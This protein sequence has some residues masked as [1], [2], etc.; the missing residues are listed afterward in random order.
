MKSSF[1]GKVLDRIN[2]IDPENLQTYLV[3]LAQDK[4]FLEGIFNSIQ[5]GIIVTDEAGKIKYVNL[6]ATRLLGL[7]EETSLGMSIDRVI[8]NLD[9]KSLLLEETSIVREVELPYPDKKF[10]SFYLVPL[11]PP[12]SSKE[13]H[14]GRALI[15][16][17]V[18][19][20]RKTTEEAIETEKLNALMLLSASVAH[21]L[22]NP[23]NSIGIHLQLMERDLKHLPKDKAEKFRDTIRI[24][25]GEIT[26]LD[27]IIS[28]FLQAMRPTP[29]DFKLEQI[30]E[31]VSEALRF[32]QPELNDREIIVETDLNKNLPKV[33]LDQN[34]IKQV[35]YNLIRNAQQ[36]MSQEGILRVE[37]SVTGDHVCVSFID[38]GQGIDAQKLARIFQP[39]YTT[40]EKGSG[41]GLMIVQRI[42][43]AHG[44]EISVQSHTGKGTTFQVLLPLPEQR[45]RMLGFNE[46]PTLKNP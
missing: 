3:R 29:P 33:L 38:S 13:E 28:Q 7:D 19:E 5:E 10:I 32:L 36:A 34:Q 37:T 26:R 31:V 40:K 15:L 12:E 25:R 44:G 39:F 6:A 20:S 8:K 24:C 11:L 18:T 9:W 16:R 27:H 42:I 14:V 23:L 43:R 35:F 30:N 4:G 45:V 21:E 2:K 41:L 1:L 46:E 17:D 22:G